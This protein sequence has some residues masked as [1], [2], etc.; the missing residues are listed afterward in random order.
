[1]TAHEWR[2]ALRANA[3]RKFLSIAPSVEPDQL[4]KFVVDELSSDDLFAKSHVCVGLLLP[5]GETIQYTST[6]A[7]SSMAKQYARR[8]QNLN[9]PLFECVDAGSLAVVQSGA[10]TPGDKINRGWPWVCVPLCRSRSVVRGVLTVDGF[11]YVARARPDESVPDSGARDF[12]EDVGV[13]IG[14]AIDWIGKR[15]EMA[16]LHRLHG[17]IRDVDASEAVQRI[18]RCGLEAIRRQLVGA[19]LSSIWAVQ[20]RLSSTLTL[21][22]R[23]VK[24]SN[25]AETGRVFAVVLLDGTE[26]ARTTETTI[27]R[28]GHLAQEVI[29]L[30]LG[31]DWISSSIVVQLWAHTSEFTE[32]GRVELHGSYYSHL[33]GTNRTYTLTANTSTRTATLTLDLS[34]CNGTSDEVTKTLVDDSPDIWD[35]IRVAHVCIQGV[36]ASGT[37]VCVFRDGDGVELGRTPAAS[38]GQCATQVTWEDI[39][40][41]VRMAAAP[42]SRRLVVELMSSRR[43]KPS[44]VVGRSEIAGPVLIA[45]PRGRA[46]RRVELT[47]C[48]L[49]D[50]RGRRKR[51][52]KVVA[53]IVA[54]LTFVD[55]TCKSQRRVEG[56]CRGPVVSLCRLSSQDDFDK[57]PVTLE[58][59]SVTDSRQAICVPPDA[60]G[61]PH[62]LI[63]PFDDLAV[64]IGDNVVGSVGTTRSF[65]VI[66]SAKEGSAEDLDFVRAVARAI[67]TSVRYVR[68]KQ[69]RDGVRAHVEQE[70]AA[71]CDVSDR[72]LIEL[73][74]TVLDMSD[75]CLPGCCS[76]V[77]L[78]QPGGDELLYVSCNARS[79]MRGNRLRRGQGISFQCVGPEPAAGQA[80]AVRGDERAHLF[81]ERATDLPFVC[82]P[83][84]ASDT[85][86][87]GVL[88]VDTFDHVSKVREGPDEPPEEGAMNFIKFVAAR[89]AKTI[90]ARQ[91]SSVLL[92]L[93]SVTTSEQLLD[94]ALWAVCMTV[95]HAIVAEIWEISDERQFRVVARMS[96]ERLVESPAQ[97]RVDA[98]VIV[99]QEPAAVRRQ[100]LRDNIDMPLLLAR[101]AEMDDLARH[102]YVLP[103]G[104]AVITELAAGHLV[105]STLYAAPG[106]C[107]CE[108]TVI[109]DGPKRL[110]VPCLQ[111]PRRLAIVVGS[112]HAA[113]SEQRFVES[114][115]Q[116]VNELYPRHCDHHEQSA[117]A[118]SAPAP[119]LEAPAPAPID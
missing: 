22:L 18:Y 91:E 108:G 102:G 38:P 107:Y 115:A 9:L 12:L 32:I 83:L 97:S 47:T 44:V 17:E 103:D 54:S 19:S 26:V 14:T 71:L 29:A 68:Q 23:I 81:G 2:T 94:W 15:D 63:A 100:V 27:D 36:I 55:V 43:G 39:A 6:T 21:R 16:L 82:V 62:R 69:L 48:R 113:H 119:S 33:P 13:L 86:I 110:V 88:G 66:D 10:E 117:P 90:R 11:E 75:Q 77:G 116:R 105:N 52:D 49:E 78:L 72:P 98:P 74:D 92:A 58:K 31:A 67:E 50:G 104:A 85:C 84:T 57:Q 87:V 51:R 8:A 35:E 79:N 109:E 37:Y 30:P 65:V 101:T 28:G 42:L 73:L 46:Q 56:L 7:G 45:L 76:Y 1:M 95:Q 64:R 40:I 3:L 4:V 99:A 93:G 41:S 106:R 70:V 25:I 20:G 118:S 59:V 96:P 112:R 60:A 111:D 114:I 34:L 61:S 89:V 80:V 53:K 24:V 5:R